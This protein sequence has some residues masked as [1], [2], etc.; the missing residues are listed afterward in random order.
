[1]FTPVMAL[2]GSVIPGLVPVLMSSELTV[3]LLASTM[4]PVTVGFPVAATVRPLSV[5]VVP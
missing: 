4:V 2:G 3:T 5:N 1:M